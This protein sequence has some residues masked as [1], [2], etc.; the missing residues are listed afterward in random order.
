MVDAADLKSATNRCS[1]SSPDTRTKDCQPSSVVERLPCKQRVAGSNPGGWHQS[2]QTGSCRGNVP[3]TGL[4]PLTADAR[5]D[6]RLVRF[7]EEG[8]AGPAVG[9][10]PTQ[11][12]PVVGFFAALTPEQKARALACQGPENHGADERKPNGP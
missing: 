1:G 5:S 10:S 11:R 12:A 9:G 3:Y 6:R 8:S 7:L 2:T 4:Q